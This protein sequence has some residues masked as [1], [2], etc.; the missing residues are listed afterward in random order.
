M[1]F[2]SLLAHHHRSVNIALLLLIV[3]AIPATFILAQKHSATKKPS[4]DVLAASTTSFPSCDSLKYCKTWAPSCDGG[5][6]YTEE[7]QCKNADGTLSYPSICPTDNTCLVSD[8]DKL[9][10]G[11]VNIGQLTF[12]APTSASPGADVTITATG[13]GQ[14]LGIYLFK[15]ADGNP[16]DKTQTAQKPDF[17]NIVSTY[18]Y[19]T[20]LADNTFYL[21]AADNVTQLITGIK[22]PALPGTY[23]FVANSHSDP[24]AG[25]WSSTD[26]A[27]P[28]YGKITTNTSTNSAN[29]VITSSATDCPVPDLQAVTVADST[30]TASATVPQNNDSAAAGTST[31]TTDESQFGYQPKI[32]PMIFV[33]PGVILVLFILF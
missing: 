27:C 11:P 15:S 5:T 16:P 7:Q 31:D 6:H 18:T 17:Y 21:L 1:R 2:S 8:T 22:L 4:S 32:D 3:I 19:N 13:S 25:W 26:R 14:S 24:L 20:P 9:T 23:Y 10:S 12:N 33:I 30:S 29:L 28:W